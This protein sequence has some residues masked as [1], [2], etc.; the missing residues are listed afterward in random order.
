MEK[1]PSEIIDPG[2]FEFIGEFKMPIE[3]DWFEKIDISKELAL[4]EEEAEKQG[5][6]GLI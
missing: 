1:F 2:E 4:I 5:K 3:K 6:K